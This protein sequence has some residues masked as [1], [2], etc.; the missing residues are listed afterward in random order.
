[1]HRLLA[2]ARRQPLQPEAVAVKGL[3]S[4]MAEL[5]VSTSGPN[6]D[7]HF[8]LPDDL[9]PAIADANQLELAVLN[10]VVNARDAMPGGGLLTISAASELVQMGERLDLSPGSYVRLS[11]KDTGT[12]I[13]QATL[14]R[15]IEPFFQPTGSV[16]VQKTWPLHGARPRFPAK[17][18]AFDLQP[19]KRRLSDQ[20]MATGQH[21]RS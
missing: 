15:A 14:A 13:D 9:L 1:M 10:L 2:F 17:R 12:E 4:G 11:V 19:A 7:V 8:E 3:V 16:R 6:V 21:N 18:R 5:F 20:F